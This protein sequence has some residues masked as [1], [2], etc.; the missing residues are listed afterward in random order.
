MT[1]KEK[2]R[3]V[4]VTA[5]GANRDR[6]RCCPT[7]RRPEHTGYV[8]GICPTFVVALAVGRG[9][10]SP[11]GAASFDLVGPKPGM[12]AYFKIVRFELAPI[13]REP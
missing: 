3:P 4:L 2:P 5:T 8:L 11:F 1:A 6:A 13:Q 9:P 10:A 7:R 12:G